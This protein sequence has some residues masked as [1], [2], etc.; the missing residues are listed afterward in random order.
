MIR[1]LLQHKSLLVFSFLFVSNLAFSQFEQKFT[2][3]ASAGTSIIVSS[4]Q[5]EDLFGPG[6]MFNG[7]LQYNF[8]RKFSLIGLAMY[9]AYT[10]NSDY[11]RVKYFNLGIGL[12]AKYKFMPLSKFRPYIL[13]G[14]SACFVRL[15]A[16]PFIREQP[17]LPGLVTGLG[18]EIDLNDNLTLFGQ[19][20]FNK[21]LPKPDDGLSPTESVYFLLGVNINMF[22]SKS[23]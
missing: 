1:K 19:A 18:A 2:L 7:G 5:N 9:G 22:K 11:F 15:E 4:Y 3:Q 8:S 14:L 20:G 23:L 21:I 16:G 6:L 17:V 13:Y 10:P 12:S